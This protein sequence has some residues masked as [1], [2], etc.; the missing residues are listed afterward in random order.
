VA[1]RD[2]RRVAVMLKLPAVDR[3]DPALEALLDGRKVSFEELVKPLRLLP[4]NHVLV[5]RRGTDEERES[6]SVARADDG[7]SLRLALAGP[8]AHAAGDPPGGSVK[9]SEAVQAILPLVEDK[10]PAVRKEAA[11]SLTILKDRTAVPALCKLLGDTN[12]GVRKAA[13]EGLEKLQDRSAGAAL[14]RRVEDNVW[15]NPWTVGV[16]DPEAGGKTAALRAL[17]ALAPEQV[18]SALVVALKG[19]EGH[20]RRWAARE[21]ASQQDR[22][23]AVPALR[24][25]VA[26]QAWYQTNYR[27]DH[28]PE[29]GGKAAAL[30]LLRELGPEQVTA[31]LSKAMGGRHYA[32]RRWAAEELVRQKDRAAV[33]ALKERVADERW[34]AREYR[35]V[36]P[37]PVG[38]GKTAALKAL[39]DLAFDE[40]T[41]PL[42]RAL[43]SKYPDQRHWAAV[44]LKV[45]G[46]RTAVPA[47][48]KRIGDE[49]WDEKTF[50]TAAGGG[51]MAALKAL[52]ALAP[53]EVQGALVQAL[54]QKKSAD[55]RK[56]AVARMAEEGRN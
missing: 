15:F 8:G 6:F 38:G 52:K 18:T 12:P 23:K 20:M 29:W 5:L 45:Q 47:L 50:D 21:L 49:T 44:E 53:G 17:R 1:L 7:K 32:M 24:E 43:F 22:K 9:A 4:G 55:V 36:D 16:E 19:K 33:P 39:R 3:N 26:A 27:G 51:K 37:D 41:E 35:N 42:T 40:A 28:D 2:Y 25:L 54:G 48:K 56:W 31:A 30:L 34:Y 10:D 46:D 14:R 13:A 11:S